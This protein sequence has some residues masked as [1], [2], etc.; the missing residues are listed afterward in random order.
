MIPAQSANE[1][2]TSR[3]YGYVA[4][5]VGALI[6]LGLRL[7]LDDVFV[8]RTFFVPYVAMVLV[9]AMLGGRGPALLAT[10]GDRGRGAE[11]GYL[12]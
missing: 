7:L 6:T 5:L 10:R 9:A 4:A 1:G 3:R 12:A 8:G 11:G 2:F